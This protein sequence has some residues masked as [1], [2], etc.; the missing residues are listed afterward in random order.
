M[1]YL[2]TC[3]LCALA[4]ASVPAQS[5]PTEITKWPDGKLAAIAITYDDSTINQFR[6]ALPLMNER[7]LVG[8]FFVITAQIPGS[9]NMPPFVGGRMGTR[10][11]DG[12][13][14]RGDDGVGRRVNEDRRVA[15]AGH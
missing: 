3:W 6:I 4:V 15:S 1:R 12:D 13:D 10:S 11:G 2:V 8:R 14:R 9:K 5:D 7:G